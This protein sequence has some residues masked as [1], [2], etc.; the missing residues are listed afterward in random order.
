MQDCKCKGGSRARGV[1]EIYWA[2]LTAQCARG[3]S[4]TC[5]LQSTSEQGH[6]GSGGCC[7]WALGTAVFLGCH[8]LVTGGGS[9]HLLCGSVCACHIG[10]PFYPLSLQ[11]LPF[12]LGVCPYILP[13]SCCMPPPSL[14]PLC[15]I[16]HPNRLE[17]GQNYSMYCQIYIHTGAHVN[18]CIHTQTCSVRN[19][20]YSIRV[21]HQDAGTE[22]NLSSLGRWACS[23][24]FPVQQ[25]LSPTEALS[26]AP[27]SQD[28]NSPRQK[29]SALLKNIKNVTASGS[30]FH[31]YTNA[32]G[33]QMK[34]GL[35]L[36]PLQTEHAMVWELLTWTHG[37]EPV[38]QRGT[39]GM[40]IHI[41]LFIHIYEQ[42]LHQNFHS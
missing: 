11:P 9:L 42:V 35:F 40:Q 26:R 25:C 30:Y 8:P 27:C 18:I 31:R 6:A 41:Q 34:P 13:H 16:P 20:V 37:Y 24:K 36:I 2:V 17:V 22:G 28:R 5:P 39:W 33:I 32:L 15:L 38:H 21:P 23:V 19:C 7:I 14:C 3:G 29:S 4:Q 1:A 10:D 12:S